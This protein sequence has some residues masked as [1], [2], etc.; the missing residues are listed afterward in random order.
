MVVW[1]AVPPRLLKPGG[2]CA[3]GASVKQADILIVNARAWTPGGTG[4]GSD[5]VAIAGNEILFMG[6]AASAKALRH[7]GTR[8]IDAQGASVLPGFIESHMHIFSGAAELDHLQLTGVKGFSELAGKVRD[9]A[10]AGGQILFGTDVGYTDAYDTE[11]EYRLMSR[12]GMG[13]HEILASLT[14]NPARRFG[15]SGRRGE[16]VPGEEADLVVLA[17]DPASDI[18]AFSRVRFTI[19]AG[20][21]IYSRE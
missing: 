6:D 5:A 15:D 2:I 18:T 16:V 10:A 9:Y 19:R 8:V 14:T 7:K 13:F 20:K 21:V 12:A 3:K 1:R 11:E 4:A 17:A